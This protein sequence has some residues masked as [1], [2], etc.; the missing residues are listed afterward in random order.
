MLVRYFFDLN[1]LRGG[2]EESLNSFV[3]KGGRLNL[4]K[5]AMIARILSFLL[6]WKGAVV[7]SVIFIAVKHYHAPPPQII[8]V[9]DEPSVSEPNSRPASANGKKFAAPSTAL[10]KN[11][12]FAENKTSDFEAFKNPNTLRPIASNSPN[13]FNTGGD[14]QGGTKNAVGGTT[15]NATNGKLSANN[16]KG[17]SP[18]TNGGSPNLSSTFTNTT[19]SN[20]TSPTTG[21]SN[22]GTS[23]GTTSV[24]PPTS[25]PAPTSTPSGGVTATQVVFTQTPAGTTDALTTAPVVQ[26]ENNVGTAATNNTGDV[27]TLTAFSVNNCVAG[28]EL[29]STPLA[30]NTQSAGASGL[31]TFTAGFKIK[32][33]NVL[34]ILATDSTHAITTACVNVTIAPGAL[35]SFGFPTQ[36]VGG[37]TTDQNLTTQPVVAAYDANGNIKTDYTNT[38]T[39]AANSNGASCG[40]PADV[41]SGISG[42]TM[43]AVA[44]IATFT[45]V[46]VLKTNAVRLRAYDGALQGCSN[47]FTLSTGVLHSIAFTTLPPTT[48]TTDDR[49]TIVA[50]EYDDHNNILSSDNT[51]SIALTAYASTDCSGGAL[52]SS[53]SVTS[54]TASAGVGTFTNFGIL[55]T[56][57]Q[58]I[59]VASGAVTNC[60]APLTVNPGAASKLAFTTQPSATTASSTAFATQPVVTIEDA[61]GN[62]ITTS[63]ASVTLSLTTGA[64]TLGGTVSMNAVAGVAD[65]TGKGLNIDLVGTNKVLTAASGTLTATTT[66]PAFTIS[67]GTASKLVFTTQPSATTASST[68]FATQP[69][70]TVEDA[71]GNTVTTSTA[72]VTL[73][74]T[75][76]AGTLGGTVSM[77]AVA[78]VANF[79]GKGLNIDTI[80]T[81]KVLTAASG[82]LT[83]ATTS[84]AF[85]ISAGAPAQ[86]VFT[87]QP[88]ATTASSTAFATQ[89]VVT[90]E[91]AAGNTVTT[92]T[93]SI[94]LSLTTGAGT[95]G[96]TVSMNAVAGVANFS[97]KGLNIDT[98]GTDKVLT[99]T[100]GALTVGTTSPAFTISAGTP[101]K[102]VFTTQPSATTASSTAFATQPVV[103]V[104]DAA[105]NTVTASTASIT[106][107][108]TTGT[109]T[110][111]GTVSMN[112]VAGV[113][114]FS[115]KGL[116]IDIAGTNKVLTATS[117]TLTVGTTSPAFTIT[118][119]T[120]AK[121][122]FTTQPSATTASSTAFA[123]QPVVTIEDAAGNTVTTSTLSVTL[124]LTTGAGTLGGTVSMSAVAG[125]A[126]FTGKGLNIDLIGTNKVLTATSGALTV[127]TTSPAFTITSGAATHL[128]FTTQPSATTASSTAFAT[129]PV[130]TIEDA[131]GNTVTTG[132]S[133]T[134]SV[135][136][137]LT[138]GAGTLGGTVS[139]SA[140]AGVAN[141]SGKGL[142]ID[143][144]GTDKV[145]TAATSIPLVGA[146]S[147]TTSP[148]FTITAGLPT[149]I[150]FTTQPSA[151]TASSTAFATQPV[152]T[153]ED[154]AGN[155]VTTS[156]L[157]V[158]LSL[159][160]GAGTLGGTVSMN[161]V[162]GIANFSGKGLNIDAV[163]T[164]KVLTAATTIP[165]LG[166]VTATTAPAF[167]ISSGVATKLVFTTQPS[168]TT[169][170]STAF[171]TQPI[172]TVEDAAGNTVT[173]STASVTLSL[174]TG[175]GTLGGTVSMNAVAGI[176][177]FSG[178]GLNIDVTGTDKVLTATSGALTVGTTS[179]AFTI[180]A[181]IPAKLVFTTQ[182]SATTASSTAF[183]TQ[184]V[185]TVEDAAGNT[186]TTSTLSV[187]LSLSTGTGTLGGTVSMSAV[188]GVADFTGKGLNID[189]AGT[190][191]V[192]T[193]TSGALT[194]ATTSPAFTITAGTASK[195]V[196]TTQPSATTA[197]ST[198][199]ATQPIVTVEDA[200]GNTVTTSTASVTLSLTTGT[201]TLGGT[202][203]MS[204]VA[205][206]ADFTGK[207]LNI[208]LVGTNKV[209]TA[210]SGALTV[211][212][213][214]PAFTITAGAATKLAFTTQPSLSTASSTA[215]AT[216]PVV[217]VEDT[218][219]NTVTTSTAS[220]T[221][222]LTT[223]A[224]TLGGTVSMSAVAGVADFTGK[225]LNI[226]LVGTN[227]VL[228]AASGAL[229][230]A[231]TSPAFTITSGVAAKLVFTT[232]PSATTASSTAFAT[233]PIVT[234]ED[235]AGNT[236]TTSTASVTLSL[237]TGTGT[238]GGTVSMSAVAGIADFTGKGLNIDLV[239][240]NKV[241]TAT[242]GALTVATTSPAFTITAGTPAKLAFTTQPSAT[243]ASSTA[244]ATQPVVTI[245]DAAG[246]TVTSSSLSITLSLTTGTGTLGGTVSMS[247]VSGVADFSGKGLNIDLAG[248]NK[249]LTASCGGLTVGTTSPAFTISSGVATKLVFTTQ[250]SATTASSTAFA[251]QPVVTVEDAAGN[252]VTTSTVSVTLSL[253]TGA[254]T[255]GGTVSMSA[256]AGIADFTGK[257]L[258]IDLVGTNKVL[259]ATSSALAVG[260][261]SPAFTIT[262]GAAT[263][264]VFTTQPSAATAS[265]TAFATQPVV[266]VEDAAGNTVTTSTVSVT[267]S[268]STGAGTLG[269][270]VSMSAVAGVAN[271]TGKGLN[272]DV[273]GADKVLTA[274]SGALTVGTT[275][276]AFTITSGAATKLVFTTQPSATTA[277]STA[278]ATQ[279]VVTIEDAA[280]NTVTSS[281]LSITLSLTTG[282]GTL[283]GTVSMNAVAGVANFS[284][285]GL[286]IDLVGTNK[287]LTATSGALTVDTTSPA[288]T[289]TASAAT[290]LVFTTQPS[291]TTVSSTAFATQPVVTI[292][293]AA[294]N[295]VTTG[296]NSTLAITL[297]LTTGT[298][299]LGGTVSMNA[300][301]GVANFSGKGL[302][303]DLVGTNKVLT[304][305][306]TIG[307]LG[308]V[309]TTTSPAFTITAGTPAQL[310]FTTQP[311]ATTASSTAFATQPIVTVEDAAGNTVTTSTL[312]VTLSLTTGT[313]TL[314]GTVSMSAVA[315]IADFSGK[316]LNI[317]LVGT[318]K[319]LTATSGAL[320]T[321]TT[322]PAFTIT[323]G[324]PTKLAFTTQ[325]PATTVSSTAFATQPVVT[326]EDAAGN[327]VTTSTLTVT[328]SLSTGTGTLGGTVSM[329]AV[330][331]IA[332]FTGKGLNIDLAGINK[333]LTATSGALTTDSTSPAFAITAGTP[334]KLAFTTQPSATTASSTAFATQP[335]VTVEDAA[336]NTV[337]TSTLSVTL[338]L[339]T[340]AG[341]LGG[342]VSMSAVA[343]I[344]DFTGKGL[345]IDLAG[346]NKVLTATSGALTVG[347]TSPA[348][349]ITA[350][351]ATKLAFTTQ[352]SATTASTAAFATQPIVTVEDAAG[353]TVTTS[354]T[355]ITLSL[356][357]GTGTLG[358]TVSMNAV[359]GIADFTGKGL[360]IDLA[361]TNKVLTAT[362][363]ALTVATTSPAFTIT[364][365]TATKLVFTTQPSATTTSSIAFA[366]QPVITV[367]DASGNT[368][369]T[370]TVS[371][372]L[373]L[374]TG[375]GS[376]GGTISMSAV[377]GIADFTGKGL[378][379]DIAGTNKVLTASSGALTTATTS[380]A[381][382]IT[383]GP[384]SKLV[385]TTQPSATTVSST[386]FATQPVIT[387]EDVAGNTVTTGSNSTLSITL[388]LSTGAGT[389]GG[390][391]SMTAVAGVA[392]FTGKG[393]NIDLAGT[394]KVIQATSTM[395][396]VGAVN[397]TTSPAFTIVAGTAAKLAFTTQP[398]ATTVSSTAFAT[399][400][401]VTVEDAAGNTVTTSTASITL[402]LTT[403]TGTLGGTVSMSA[404]AG[405]ANFSG[406]G[407]NIDLTGTNKVLTATSGALTVATTSPAFTITAG[408]AA[409]LAFTTQPS[410]TTVSSTA[411]ATQPVVTVEDAAGNTVTTST[412]S[413][414][415]SLTTG[416]GT[417]GG[418]VSMSA[419]AGVADFTG[420][421]LNI[422]LAGTNK[423]LTATSGG[424]TVATTS[425]A[426]TITAGIANKLV[427]TTQPSATS[428]TS[429][430]F[431]TQ[432]VVTI[433]DAA[434]NTVTTSTLSITLSLTTGAGT[435][436]GTLSMSAVAGVA[437][438]TGKGLNIDTV[439]TD[440]VL[441]ATSGGLTVAT[442][443]P[444]FTI[445]SS[446]DHF[447]FS[448]TD[449]TTVTAGT[450]FHVQL[451]AKKAD[452]STLTTFAGTVSFAISGSRTAGY[453]TADPKTAGAITAP[454]TASDCVFDGSESGVKTCT[455]T[456][457]QT[458]TSWVITPSVNA[459]SL[460]AM[461][462]ITVQRAA[463][464][465]YLKF[466]TAPSPTTITAGTAFTTAPQVTAYDAYGNIKT[467][468]VNS[469]ITLA[470][471]NGTCNAAVTN[472]GGGITQGATSAASGVD[473]FA[474]VTPVKHSVAALMAYTSAYGYYI[475]Q[476]ITV[477]TGALDHISFTQAGANGN[478][479]DGDAVSTAPSG[480]VTAGTAFST[481]PIVT[482]Y[483]ASG[484]VISSDSTHSVTLAGYDT[485]TTC[486]KTSVTNTLDT[487]NS[488]G[489]TTGISATSLSRT[490][491]SGVAG[492]SPTFGSV[493][494]LK[495]SVT[496][497]VA[498]MAVGG[499]TYYSCSSAV[500]VNPAAIA[501]LAFTTNPSPLTFYTTD[502]VSNMV[503]TAYDT[504]SNIATN[505][506]AT[507]TLKA[508]DTWA[509]CNAH[510]SN[511]ASA[512]Y[513]ASSTLT[514]SLSS[515]TA[516]FSGV[517]ID[518]TIGAIGPGV[519][520]LGA[521]DGSHYACTNA[522]DTSGS[523]DLSI[524]DPSVVVQFTDD[525]GANTPVLRSAY[526]LKASACAA[527][528]TGSGG[529]IACS[530]ATN[531]VPIGSA[532]TISRTIGGTLYS[533]AATQD[534]YITTYAITA[535]STTQ[536]TSITNTKVTIPANTSS[537]V[538]DSSLLTIAV[539][540]T[541]TADTYFL[542]KIASATGATVGSSGLA[543]IH[544][545]DPNYVPTSNPV[546]N[547]G[548]G[549]FMFASP[550]VSST[551]GASSVNVIIQR[552]FTNSGA[553]SSVTLNFYSGSNGIVAGTTSDYTV[554]GVTLATGTGTY[555]SSTN[556]LT[557]PAGVTEQTINVPITNRTDGINKSFYIQI[558]PLTHA[559]SGTITSGSSVISSVT[560]TN[561]IQV[562][563][564]I[565]GQGI[566]AN[567]TVTSVDSTSVTLNQNATSTIGVVAGV[568]PSGG[569]FIATA[570]STGTG[571][572]L[573]ATKVRILSTNS[574]GTTCNAA[575]APFG[576]GSGTVGSPW[577]IC[578]TTQ[579]SAITGN[580]CSGATCNLSSKYFQLMADFAYGSPP[581]AINGLAAQIDGNQYII[582]GYNTTTNVAL[583]TASGGTVNQTGA[584]ITV[585]NL[586]ML[587]A[588]VTNTAAANSAML[589]NR[590]G[591]NTGTNYMAKFVD[592]FVSGYLTTSQINAG[593]LVGIEWPESTS[594]ADGSI[595]RAMTYGLL[596]STAATTNNYV[597][598]IIGSTEAVLNSNNTNIDIRNSFSMTNVFG[599]GSTAASG[600]FGGVLGGAWCLNN[601]DPPN[602][603]LDSDLSTGYV[604]GGTTGGRTGGITGTFL[605]GK[606]NTTHTVQYAITNSTFT[607]NVSSLM[608]FAGGM[609][610]NI[611][612]S[613]TAM[614][615]GCQ[616]F[617][618]VL[619]S[620]TN[621]G[622]ISG[623]VA[624]SGGNYGGILGLYYDIHT[625]A[626]S[627]VTLQ[628]TNNAN[629]G[630]ISCSGSATSCGNLG[631]I[632][633]IIGTASNP[634]N[635]VG[636]Q[637][638]PQGLNNKILIS[639]NTNSGTVTGLAGTEIGGVIGAF[640]V[641]G[642]DSIIMGSVN[643]PNI[644]TGAI[645]CG[646][647]STMCGGFAGELY[648]ESTAGTPT[649]SLSYGAATGPVSAGATYIGGF[650][651][652]I[653]T[654]ASST[655]LVTVSDSYSTGTITTT[656]TA[657]DL[658]GFAGYIGHGS[659]VTKAYTNSNIV[660][661]GFSSTSVGGFAGLLTTGSTVNQSWSTGAIAAN[662]ANSG[663]FVGTA[664]ATTVN[665]SYTTGSLAGGTTAG[666]FIGNTVTTLSTFTGCYSALTSIS[667]TTKKGFV[668]SNAT[669]GTY[670][671]DY[672]LAISGITDT[673]VPVTQTA[674][675]SDASSAAVTFTANTY[676][677]TTIDT[678]KIGGVSSVA[679]LVV[680]QAISGTGV[681]VGATIA[682][683]NAGAYSLTFIA[684]NAAVG[685]AHTT[686]TVTQTSIFNNTAFDS[687]FTTT[688]YWVAPNASCTTSGCPNGTY[689]YPVLIWP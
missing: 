117:G 343:G 133:S 296:A 213:T 15:A 290:Q 626:L 312:S 659:T 116:N 97:G 447:T 517:K 27:V 150:A 454:N 544:L 629:T 404:A 72:S 38:V 539:N 662:G 682:T 362:N 20:T 280:G 399:Q 673:V 323:A 266:T 361:G 9:D 128:V 61:A 357:T 289:I 681:P 382:T 157:S 653:I 313:G 531:G 427:F 575:G 334:A 62:T 543:E 257:G 152:V 322:S 579:W 523:S 320:T 68:A 569:A 344:A 674:A 377:A 288:F 307:G 617:N 584:N 113:A 181:G 661:T 471:D 240:T 220:I 405:I 452:N 283:G 406:K 112:A 135:T 234:V 79:S 418:T 138:T 248:T 500:T 239:G 498:S 84:P 352:P 481:Q 287:V 548:G 263:Q 395:A 595:T 618:F 444:A 265:S 168:A 204:A 527:N 516:T 63:T 276:P 588:T 178:K 648:E 55:K 274:T 438:F 227:K 581:T 119:G 275:S 529:T 249:A 553:A 589:M 463:S 172:V 109:G 652:K 340:G 676:T 521:D 490:L 386:A 5:H 665:E 654:G 686:T 95:L 121:L 364:S 277:S 42:N 470:G 39:L 206:I 86:L 281:T 566:P 642:Y 684:P 29:G 689:A 685:T 380:P 43:A 421:G 51:S 100:S 666:G 450:T 425:P 279:P 376:L 409:K 672:W 271:F 310:A 219:G 577:L 504:Y 284:G 324:T 426:F 231:T 469:D 508:Y 205:G 316:G 91:D 663:G 54:A 93:L 190:N 31:V 160:T 349:T 585:Q 16:G 329:N 473:T 137:S 83:A 23:G 407:L 558:A 355:S 347:T 282:T 375:N 385:F 335:I 495:T 77:N 464:I 182:P 501:S 4:H 641:A 632:I 101:A 393:L 555:N 270:T 532:I 98:A 253:S 587:N 446:V 330:A 272:I 223:G 104:E 622:S 363:G 366:T 442:T 217:T 402:S 47:T 440:K 346:T 192:L 572:Q 195:L 668:G 216:Q 96:G 551:A 670:T 73:S 392:D 14:P 612:C 214:S 619:D 494:A 69:V 261:T 485:G 522:S 547:S 297:S 13:T 353:N 586:N 341:T 562:G 624:A 196:F 489:A 677:T 606:P 381:F 207:G 191:K 419:V 338:S 563:Q 369:T 451:T 414:T 646:S 433:E 53:L 448:Y 40:S 304:A 599:A 389:L 499:T 513:N 628:I 108:L 45:S 33:T 12:T 21:T 64:G 177:N 44:G 162:A 644:S 78:G 59:Q 483:D 512:F 235:A 428:V 660:D 637:A 591:Y 542:L 142:N 87:T 525:S 244:F 71:A 153:I 401:V 497:I 212:T 511:T 627:T 179:P 82:T 479:S 186:V 410:A 398:S 19:N 441:T 368:V 185:V 560:N 348:F 545:I 105:G 114:D 657:T 658:G 609:L 123:T 574:T 238:L 170:S 291:A 378:N 507:I 453:I 598:G 435:L 371:V 526:T 36:P 413:I 102:L 139:M 258:N 140:V 158:T 493:T 32:K 582:N 345:N 267:L 592:V 554:S 184:P 58:S 336:G 201:G 2:A 24:M 634:G 610:G 314:G 645:N 300:V 431:A 655:G 171:A 390:T 76:G 308:G 536:F 28:N 643:A 391:V 573:S 518:G 110:L 269:G 434:G 430:A 530:G 222:S 603:N 593:F 325:P 211:A 199:F 408:A 388:S 449:T 614:A 394:D 200:A 458:G 565:T 229:I 147:T 332:D 197:S 37:N 187:T 509:H 221:L 561:L 141:F 259:T 651:G 594:G 46:D 268:L 379:I 604:K 417:L 597:G 224:G 384:A 675:L 299:T 159:T 125:I 424:L 161:A 146:V 461:S 396:L 683:I 90:I 169:A 387:I 636:P 625:T 633:G 126:D 173:T 303:I 7:T 519:H 232:Q 484:N 457:D 8:Y 273:T 600:G 533:T 129:Q 243:T 134:L 6:S 534:V 292:E 436:G 524:S 468:I 233:Q 667:G 486:T 602:L 342:T 10:A 81:D 237:T 130:V 122:A 535:Q 487:N 326:I 559:F 568:T 432:P 397:T 358:G 477:N 510:T 350:G 132:A 550:F 583:F 383:A 250:P 570:T 163:G 260:T 505:G 537:V 318:N 423:V 365:G 278:F 601:L 22:T 538:V 30:S 359:A 400:P 465:A 202:V 664:T 1:L 131:A 437:D 321:A 103:T 50:T 85:T 339:T 144:V 49:H 571:R 306:A 422:D 443:S 92:S 149:Q 506:S 556:V 256:V 180:S 638:A 88:S 474:T 337:T 188:A 57:V 136:L 25:T 48:S 462:A 455:F 156:T 189:V 613:G 106:L 111:G 17:S 679:G 11:L 209:L 166:S 478:E 541:L 331:G 65:F 528:T 520:R 459:I 374:T 439:G 218:A 203:S 35:A 460:T 354:T 143:L 620:D 165:L 590:N 564:T 476:N 148:A 540:A 496:Q 640:A 246:N 403:G 356:T 41:A 370:S 639:G 576:G 120:P 656:A 251:T 67:A 669:A 241:L 605:M 247:A 210:T 255:L 616:G 294:G 315:G 578:S 285:K 650:V 164:D 176:A 515:G 252:T 208:D 415:L 360:N 74:L 319:V 115:G 631:G 301:A 671:N 127:A 373:S 94:T 70:V 412:A 293:D 328:L 167:T 480:T 333:V 680:G 298:G 230:V 546:T 372:T 124:S 623:I 482:A 225:G 630:P 215:F 26:L 118:A 557:F 317:N 194:V 608:Y 311:S 611:D 183:A 488:G 305:A 416:T 242:S 228:T 502:I 175:A 549:D 245:E 154:A 309:T 596:N 302:N 262:A 295:T 327:T 411:F 580:N 567:T 429:T 607:G 226:D 107:S 80:G 99:A 155:T 151:T 456:F 472:I 254:G 514:A 56:S 467:N 687:T 466:T 649:L 264:L 635:A 236:V 445:I 688:N 3:T 621:T 615:Y 491:A 198:A 286:N 34:S 420:K 66:S 492:A 552:P 193:A 75:T 174:T 89:P 678:I 18:T 351:T 503:V 60:L 145:L 367:E 52:G 647:T 475:C